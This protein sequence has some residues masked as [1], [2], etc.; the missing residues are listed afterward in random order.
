MGWFEF[1]KN[2]AKWQKVTK[3]DKKFPELCFW[4]GTRRHHHT[5]NFWLLQCV[6]GKSSIL[7]GISCCF[8][9][10]EDLYGLLRNERGT[11]GI[12]YK[13][14]GKIRG[15]NMG[16]I[17]GGNG[18]KIQ[19]GNGGRNMGYPG[20]SFYIL[21]WRTCPSWFSFWEDQVFV[22]FWCSLIRSRPSLD[23]LDLL[24]RIK[25]FRDEDL[26]FSPLLQN[27]CWT[28][29]SSNQAYWMQNHW[30]PKIPHLS[31]TQR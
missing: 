15:G 4:R 27:F 6:S 12:C 13:N 24:F 22:F 29:R 7:V 23:V 30:R 9:E 17:R 28:M 20:T 26:Y 18:G 2:E 3:S 14:M 16:G 11:S 8:W 31:P 19:G 1:G 5:A 10:R 21:G 25:L